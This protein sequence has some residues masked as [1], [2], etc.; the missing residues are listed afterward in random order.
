MGIE[1]ATEIKTK[2]DKLNKAEGKNPQP[3][4]GSGVSEKDDERLENII[5]LMPFLQQSKSTNQQGDLENAAIGLQLVVDSV[6]LVKTIFGNMKVFWNNQAR[7][8][9]RYL[10]GLDDYE[11]IEVDFSDDRDAY[12]LQKIEERGLLW[13]VFGKIVK[14]GYDEI[15][16]QQ[17]INSHAFFGKQ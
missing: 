11:Q 16:R 17:E 14:V 2:L 12:Y 8:I 5:R 15:A 6:K 13:L 1:S 9:R 10:Q 4:Y 3:H 7:F